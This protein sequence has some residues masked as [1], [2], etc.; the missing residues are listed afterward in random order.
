[1]NDANHRT[2]SFLRQFWP[3]I[4][5][6]VLIGALSSVITMYR[7]QTR[8]NFLTFQQSKTIDSLTQSVDKLSSGFSRLN[9]EISTL[10]GK[11]SQIQQDLRD[12][13]H[14]LDSSQDPP[15]KKAQD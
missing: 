13:G 8:L 4:L 7:D 1:M 5:S 12:M 11:I 10:R 2:Q 3:H 9:D 6:Y 14:G 15:Q